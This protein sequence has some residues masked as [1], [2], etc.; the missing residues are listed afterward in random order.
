[1]GEIGSWYKKQPKATAKVKY[2]DR[3][4]TSDNLMTNFPAMGMVQP[5]H[6]GSQSSPPDKEDYSSADNKA[7]D[8]EAGYDYAHSQDEVSRGGTN[9]LGPS[10]GPS[11]R[12]IYGF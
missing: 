5:A 3:V 9:E 6:L 4:P 1:M 8:S 12:E 2:Q 11:Q 10:R 7:S